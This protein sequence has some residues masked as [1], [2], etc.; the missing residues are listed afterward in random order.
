MMSRR[1]LSAIIMT[2]PSICHHPDDGLQRERVLSD[3]PVLTRLYQ[4]STTSL[5]ILR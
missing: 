4:E 3:Y 1:P 5:S 2:A